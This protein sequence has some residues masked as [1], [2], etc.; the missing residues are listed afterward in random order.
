[1]NEKNKLIIILA[2][3]FIA[4]GGIIVVSVFE[5]EKSEG[6]YNEFVADFNSNEEQ[7]IYLGRPTCD[8][9]TLLEPSLEDLSNRYGFDYNYINTDE[10][11][12]KY[13]NE[14]AED[15]GL[16]S[17]STPYLAI[18][19]NGEIVAVQNEYKD[20]DLTFEFLQENKIIDSEEELAINYIDYETYDELINSEDKHIIVIGQ[21]TCIYCVESKVVFNKI[22][23]K[24]DI[25]IN[26][27]NLTYLTTEEMELFQE[28]FAVFAEG[29]G[30][31]YLVIVEDN[32]IIDNIEGLATEQV[33]ISLFEEM[34]II[35]E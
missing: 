10:I 7:L 22:L 14:I 4:I 2:V 34:G 23:D 13:M 28:S 16:T 30:T 11:S 17:I 3:L 6:M 20:S 35:N 15:L 24:Y 21:S 19:K 33:Y 26:Y 32:E 9:C 12:D 18:V 25:E 29:I 27:L 1:M 8:Y 31:P 5:A